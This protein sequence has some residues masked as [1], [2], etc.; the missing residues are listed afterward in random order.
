MNM[1]LEQVRDAM[2]AFGDLGG[3]ESAGITAVCTDSR[4]VEGGELFVCLTGERFDGHAFALK[5]V[6]RGVAAVVAS[7]PLDLPPHVPQLMVPDTLDALGRL[8]GAWRAACAK[9]TTVVAVTGSSGKTTVKQMLAAI[10]SRVGETAFNPGNLNNRIGVPRTILS[11]T[12]REKFWVLELGINLPGEMEAL[13]AM[14]RPDVAVVVNAAPVHLAGLGSLEG[15]ARA[16]ASLLT[17]MTP[18]GMAVI[19]A[20]H[21]V[22]DAAVAELSLDVS[23]LRFTARGADGCYASC[24]YLGA[25]KGRGRYRLRLYRAVPETAMELD[26]PVAGAHWAENVAAAATAAHALGAPVEAVRAGLEAVTLPDH[27]F[28][29]RSL[30]KLTLIDDCYNANPASMVAAVAGAAEMAAETADGE[31]GGKAPLVLVLGDMLELG[32]AAADMHRDLGRTIAASEPSAVIWHGAHAADVS[33]GL[34]NGHWPGAFTALPEEGAEAALLEALDNL[35]LERG[36]ILVKGS[37]GCRME[38]YVAALAGRAEAE[39]R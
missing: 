37:R 30:G 26:L 39:E 28:D 13:G 8:A 25:R 9:G 10:L 35:Q 16:K 27:R 36:V 4:L 1:T 18:G 20:D 5:A 2:G 3:R 12:G 21:P 33:S 19:G 17:W 38:R 32:D 22:L 24:A 11:C 23:P 14:T 15:V 34:G 29:V 6:E 7:R 31:G